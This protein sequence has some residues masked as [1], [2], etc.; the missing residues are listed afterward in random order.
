MILRPVA[1]AVAVTAVV[2]LS[3]FSLSACG[4]GASEGKGSAEYVTGADG[5]ATVARGERRAAG[6][7]KGESLRGEPLD[8]A[9]YAG[10]VVVVNVWGSWCPPCRAEA[11]YLNKV[12]EETKGKG[13]RFV[14]INTR[15]GG[16]TAPRAFEE[17]YGVSYP[18]FYDPAG[19][20][21]LSGFPAGTVN[22]Q[23]LPATV[24]LDRDGKIASRVFGGIDDT[25]LHKMI[26]PLVREN[27]S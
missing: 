12:A 5:I 22:L 9:D 18:S 13:V 4:G 20:V 14:G 11:P 3:S 26:A 17:D 1:R 25:K 27:P 2:T 16:R 23:G 7:M 6:P 19:K 15:D 8:V 24:V 10:D 21:I